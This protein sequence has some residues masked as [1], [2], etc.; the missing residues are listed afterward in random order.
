MRV[1]LESMPFSSF[2]TLLFFN[3]MSGT[4]LCPKLGYNG[5]T[6]VVLKS[7]VPLPLSYEWFSIIN[8]RVN[9]I[10]PSRVGR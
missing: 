3:W 4:V 9:I 8:L 5:L 6:Y 1:K 2:F 10:V 7:E